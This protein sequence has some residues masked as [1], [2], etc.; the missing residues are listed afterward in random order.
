MRRTSLLILLA[1]L[2]PALARAQDS[3]PYRPFVDASFYADCT[4]RQALTS[5]QR[6]AML[7]AASG[8]TL[9]LRKGCRILLPTPGAGS[10]ALELPT[11]TKIEGE[12]VSAGFDVAVKACADGTRVGA[13]CSADADC[14]SS[15]C[16]G[17]AF[18][19]TGGSTYTMISAAS[20]AADVGVSNVSLRARGIDGYGTCAGGSNAGKPCLRV[21]T[22]DT[23][24]RCTLNA[25]CPSAGTCTDDSFCTG[26]GGSCT[27]AP[28]SPS[29]AG[30]IVG[31]DLA[32]SKRSRTI[33]VQAWDFRRGDFVFRTGENG[34]AR[35]IAAVLQTYTYA[36]NPLETIGNVVSLGL[37]AAIHDSFIS[38][39][40]GVGIQ[41]FT[42][43]GWNRITGN[44]LTGLLASTTGVGKH[45]FSSIVG[46]TFYNLAI[47]AYMSGDSIFTG[48]GAYITT[49]AVHGCINGAVI[50]DNAFVFAGG[51]SLGSTT[52][53]VCGGVT[54]SKITGNF[55]ASFSV[56]DCIVGVTS[57]KRCSD[58]LTTCVTNANCTPTSQTCLEAGIDH[59]VF[60]NNL[61]LTGGFDFS[62]MGSGAGKFLANTIGNNYF[63]GDLAMPTTCGVS[64]GS[65]VHGNT[66][67][68]TTTGVDNWCQDS[69]GW[70]GENFNVAPADPQY[71]P[72]LML[73]NEDGAAMVS[74]EAV[75][76]Y[77]SA[78]N[79]V[80]RATTAREV[81]G[82][83]LTTEG[84]GSRV[85]VLTNGMA[86]CVTT[87]AAVVAG[88]R[89]RISTTAG[90]GEVA[91][92][93]D[94]AYAI[95]FDTAADQGAYRTVRCLVG[96]TPGRL[97]TARVFGG[98]ETSADFTY[99]GEVT[100][101]TDCS[102]LD[103]SCARTVCRCGICTGSNGT[104]TC[105]LDPNSTY[106]VM[107]EVLAGG[108]KP[109]T[110]LNVRNFTHT[111]GTVT[112]TAPSLVVT[113]A[114]QFRPLIIR[115][116]GNVTLSG[117][118]LSVKGKG[119]SGGTG[120]AALSTTAGRASGALQGMLPGSLGGNTSGTG[121]AV[122]NSY[123]QDVTAVMLAPGACAFGAG[124]GGGPA[125]VTGN[126]GAAYVELPS[127][128]LRAGATGGGGG[129]C[130]GSA[131]GTNG[132]GGAGGGTVRIEA[133]GVCTF[134]ATIDA[135][136]DDGG[137]RAGG[138]GGGFVHA[139]CGAVSGSN[140]VDSGTCTAGT[141]RIC[142][143]GGAGGAS[144]GNCG[145]G[146][147]GG[148]GFAFVETIP[149]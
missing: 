126:G 3:N 124:T 64:V 121:G 1:V 127:F 75:A 107:Q 53:T 109:A 29:G 70:L 92:P 49:N 36:I 11:G 146:G 45:G 139:L 28:G 129:G 113:G 12:D 24:L 91:L 41:P 56:F 133:G 44:Y 112:V 101:P 102:S 60:D 82:I 134:G 105:T 51:A 93:V 110:V 40:A 120:G 9:G 98:V 73:T 67:D 117:G 103:S 99:A 21:C 57:G 132:A 83:V 16:P 20:G 85:Q 13:A 143:G 42:G 43:G 74:G 25:Q 123:V 78:A 90:R 17:T 32:N 136:G 115:A 88:D 55:W 5:G 23:S 38:L 122:G 104:G 89:L 87:D 15:T 65:A 4:G 46:N 80:R 69:S 27:G 79:A 47:G 138:G 148:D 142:V 14:P 119:G 106:G 72:L 140:N 31:V 48:N 86:T 34:K 76:A 97:K 58:Q 6:T 66:F 114:T 94:D 59:S 84:D 135:Q 125:P 81:L 18:A 54:H 108:P 50:A 30:K 137:A 95:A 39:G 149:K 8:K 130:A 10:S 63:G 77:E 96:K 71:Q 35:D 7:A 118:T 145:A 116:S 61:C 19:P 144:G 52:D 37:N 62:G 111:A 128:C 141:P 26:A 147:A 2:A 68:G 100:S 33:N 22:T 131:S